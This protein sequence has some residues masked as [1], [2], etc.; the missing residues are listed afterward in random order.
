MAAALPRLGIPTDAAY[1]DAALEGHT[2]V[3]EEKLR[4]NPSLPPIYTS[5]VGYRTEG[6]RSTWK[7]ADEVYTSG[8]GDCE[9]LSTWRAAELRV[10]GEDPDA[11]AR[12]YR[13]GSSKFH[14]VVQ[15]GDGRI[16]DP[17]L[18]LGMPVRQPDIYVSKLA[19]NFGAAALEGVDDDAA[20]EEALA[21]QTPPNEDAEDD[22]A[23]AV[24][25][26]WHTDP[27]N[28]LGP[29]VGPADSTADYGYNDPRDMGGGGG[30]GSSDGGGGGGGQYPQQPQGPD[31]G[32]QT[33]ADAAHGQQGQGGGQQQGRGTPGAPTGR[34]P[35][36]TSSAKPP[37]SKAHPSGSKAR[38]PSKSPTKRKPISKG[39]G[40][41]GII[42]VPVVWI[43]GPDDDLAMQDPEEHGPDDAANEPP[44]DDDRD[45]SIDIKKTDEGDHVAVVSI[46]TSDGKTINVQSTKSSTAKSAASK[47]YNITKII[48]DDPNVQ[49][50]LPPQVQATVA[51]LKS[52]T[53]KKIYH[54]LF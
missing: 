34:K 19:D 2:Q 42:D 6:N 25:D 51:I 16:E 4:R 22:Q 12:T 15:L 43:T 40:V 24:D 53:A 35:P 5:G 50:L 27:S 11:R 18:I 31:R 52:D 32:A 45:V 30:G 41:H 28:D 54:S 29:G 47:A 23:R 26:F 33:Y 49:K 39:R 14:A 37:T 8:V 38:P 13:T 7:L 46:P 3:N 20:T 44:A 36:P 21:M 48:A 10:S 1:F 9:A 17:S